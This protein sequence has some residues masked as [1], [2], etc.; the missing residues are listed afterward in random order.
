MKQDSFA[1][2]AVA[3]HI[4]A[5]D[6]VIVA[7]RDE[8]TAHAIGLF[9]RTAEHIVTTRKRQAELIGEAHRIFMALMP[10]EGTVRAVIS[11]GGGWR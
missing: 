4:A 6:A 8:H 5:R 3:L 1:E 9:P 7:E 10:V 11:A 2:I